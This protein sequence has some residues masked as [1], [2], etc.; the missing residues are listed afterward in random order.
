M[1][2]QLM[3]LLSNSQLPEQ[4]PRQQAEIELKH[5][6]TNPAYPPA[7]A[8]V[9]AHTSVETKIRQA[10]LSTL[11]LFIEA[12]WVNDQF[13]SEPAIPIADDAKAQ[14]RQTLLDLAL[15]PEEDR[16]VKVAVR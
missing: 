3:Q 11:R 13:N 16:K 8:N 7:L 10:A 12:N 5:A 4:A 9:A 6:S 2:D 1:E 15:S 14:I